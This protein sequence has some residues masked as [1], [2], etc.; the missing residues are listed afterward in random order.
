M[1]FVRTDY[2]YNIWSSFIIIYANLLNVIYKDI[3]TKTVKITWCTY[4]RRRCSVNVCIYIGTCS[5]YTYIEYKYI[6]LI[7]T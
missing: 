2:I 3:I 1:Y 6:L 7:Y 4:S 5:M